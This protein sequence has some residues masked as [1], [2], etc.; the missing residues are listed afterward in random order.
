MKVQSIAAAALAAVILAGCG[1]KASFNVA[2][3]VNGLA[4]PGLVLQNGN[5]T[6]SVPAGATSFSFPNAISYGTEYL[7][8]V[9]SQPNHMECTVVPGTERGS[10]G[11]TAVINVQVSC[12]QKT[13]S[14]GGSVV[15]LLGDQLVIVNGSTAG[16]TTIL[17][18]ATSF[19]YG[20]KIPV[21]QSYGL[22]VLTQPKDPA[23]VCTIANG[24]DVMGDADRANVVITCQ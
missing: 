14:V 9:K 21:G 11:H 12:V 24:T 4:N 10:A 23:Q 5:D 18:G 17:K 13:Y 7:V 15:N 1:G 2:G 3:T 19:T 6:I 20:S 22:T 8:S 16:S